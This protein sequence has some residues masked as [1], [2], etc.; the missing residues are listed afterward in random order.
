MDVE[1][2]QAPAADT[3]LVDGRKSPLRKSLV[4]ALKVATSLGLLAIL[5]SRVNWSEVAARLS[6]ADFSLV[7][8]AIVLLVIATIVSGLRWYRLMTYLGLDARWPLALRATF[9]GWF[10]GQF[11]P[12]TLGGDTAR[13]WFLWRARQPLITGLH[14]AILDRIVA[15]IGVLLLILTSLPHLFGL[16]TRN[17][18]WA[19]SG[20]TLL[21]S[22]AV[23][24]FILIGVP[25]PHWMR[26][27][28]AGDVLNFLTA[29]RGSLISAAAAQGVALSLII[30]LLSIGAVV[31]IA[32]AIGVPVGFRDSIGIVA[33]ATLLAAIPISI[34]GWG[35]RE[36]TMVAGFSLLGVAAPDALSISI[37]YGLCIM[38]SVTPG[39]LM[40]LGN[41]R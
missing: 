11:L 3:G 16:T 21:L 25:L 40:W 24:L 27:G 36:G 1:L 26:R 34:N 22:G 18:A 6:G 14:S 10:V 12:G 37:L 4:F 9:A 15:L 5:G 23:G 20:A 7:G 30:H 38:A 8:L 17:L 33:A 29:L 39:S 2:P 41:W 31:L 35:V 13:V 32:H 28:R 19:A